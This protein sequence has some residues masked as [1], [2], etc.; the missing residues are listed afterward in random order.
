MYEDLNAEEHLM[1]G[2]LVDV[3]HGSKVRKTV[4]DWVDL[5]L[6]E[7]FIHKS[8]EILLLSHDKHHQFEIHEIFQ[9]FSWVGTYSSIFFLSMHFRLLADIFSSKIHISGNAI[10]AI[11]K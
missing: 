3:F 9:V 10:L 6:A 1:K 5:I 8:E 7:E 11:L 4:A 2:V